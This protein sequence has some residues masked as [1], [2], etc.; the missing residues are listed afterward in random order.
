MTSIRETIISGLWRTRYIVWVLVLAVMGWGWWTTPPVRFN[1]TI[2]GFFPPDN[3][4]LRNYQ[5]TEQLFGGDQL[6]FVVYDDPELWTPEGMQRIA[7]LTDAVKDSVPGIARVESLDRMP[8][9]WRVDAAV[10]ELASEERSFKSLVRMLKARAD[11]KMVVRHMQDEPERLKDLRTRLCAHPLFNGFVL[12]ETGGSTAV[13]ARL[14]KTHKAKQRATIEKLREVADQFAEEQGVANIAV[15]GPPVLIV[16]GFVRLE[17]DNRTLGWVAMVLM[18]I[19][20]L[21]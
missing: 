10:A 14:D 19:V 16:D 3:P 15:A 7:T 20:M 17:E 6:V 18:S 8:V 11:V 2:E 5:K 21:L 12:D 9:P 4:A 1:Q 13:I